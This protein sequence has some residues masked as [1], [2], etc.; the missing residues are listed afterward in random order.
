MLLNIKKFADTSETLKEAKKNVKEMSLAK[1]IAVF[2]GLYAI[3]F[4][5][6]LI[7]NGI[8]EV[9]LILSNQITDYTQ[10]LVELYGVIFIK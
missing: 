7:L 5:I 10:I 9:T 1:E 3:T 2:I 6:Q 8:I 4:F